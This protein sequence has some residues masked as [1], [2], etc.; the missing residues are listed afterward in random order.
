MSVLVREEIELAKAEMSQKI[1]S[2]ARGAVGFAI[3]A[4]FGLLA[5]PFGL[6]T[7]AYGLDSA[8]SSVWLGFLIVLG[9]LVAAAAAAGFFAFRKFKGATP[10]T[11]S[12]AI[13]EA[14]KIRE[15]VTVRSESSR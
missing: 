4:V 5:I 3:A 12:M 6:L 11:P 13:D 8:L 7:L 1:A 10:P 2:L 14:K 15:T 9:V